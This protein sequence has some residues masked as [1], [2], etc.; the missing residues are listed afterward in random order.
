MFLSLYKNIFLKWWVKTH[1]TSCINFYSS[2]EGIK[3]IVAKENQLMNLCDELE[4][5]LEQ[6]EKESERLMEVVVGNII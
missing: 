3:R 5:Q 6:S 4:N 2:I 1:I